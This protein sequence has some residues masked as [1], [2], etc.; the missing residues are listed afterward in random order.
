MRISAF[1]DLPQKKKKIKK[2]IT[3]NSKQW[4]LSFY[5]RLNIKEIK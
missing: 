1:F 3:V 2:K 4:K 5:G